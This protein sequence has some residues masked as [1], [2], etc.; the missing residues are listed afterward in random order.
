MATIPNAYLKSD[1]VISLRDPQ[2]AA[3]MFTDD[4][5]RL[6]PKQKF[7]FH[8]AFGINPSALITPA[9]VSRHRNEINMLVKTVELP[10]FTMK[11]ETVNQYNRKKNVQTGHS[12][13]A[14]NI[15]FHDDNMGLINQ[16]WQNYYAYYYAD[17][18]TASQPGTYNRTATRKSTF[19]TNN[20]GLDNG[21][22]QPFFNYIKIY[23]MARGEYVSYTLHNPVINSF[24]H[25]GLDYAAGSAPHDNQMSVQFEAVSYDAGVVAAGDPEGF[26]LEHYDLTP[27]PLTGVSEGLVSASP[28]FSTPPASQT[29]GLG[30]LSNAIETVNSYT[31]TKPLAQAGVSI[32]SNINGIAGPGTGGLQGFAFP[33]PK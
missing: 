16:L 14:I 9:L 21:S 7:L 15:K 18:Q 28:N 3:R 22:T 30:F 24:N 4:N 33:L 26:A 10:N 8:V 2:H 5:L 29:Q 23:Q 11:V 19:I 1:P 27:S 12:F 6:A 31:N 25:N 32:N 13:N 20:Y 17:S